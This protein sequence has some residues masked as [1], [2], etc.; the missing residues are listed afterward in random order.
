MSSRRP[1]GD[2]DSSRAAG[3]PSGCQEIGGQLASVRASRQL[4]VADV[5]SRLILSKAQVLGLETGDVSAFYGTAFFLKGLRKYMAFAELPTDGLDLALARAAEEEAE[6]LRL[7]QADAGVP[8]ALRLVARVPRGAWIA[9]AVVIVIG[10]AALGLSRYR[11]A[12]R[13]S[14]EADTVRLNSVAPLPAHPLRVAARTSPP[15]AANPAT[16]R[17]SIAGDDATVRVSVGKATWVFVRFP[18]NRVMERGL[19]AGEE[20]EV[21]PL[22]VYLAIGTA[23]S[24]DLRVEDRPVALEP[25]IRNNG[26]VRITKP[27]LAALHETREP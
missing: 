8:P 19:A 26:E 6:T 25:Y 27:Q 16:I 11:P 10:G 13:V 4:S 3:L 15:V 23:D 18:D 9:A 21:G 17:T 22:P 12:T 1:P 14:E 20:L 5:A 7:A 2:G 24:V